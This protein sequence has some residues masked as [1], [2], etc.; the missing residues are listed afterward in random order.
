MNEKY[1][2]KM[3]SCIPLMFKLLLLNCSK[4]TFSPNKTDA[5]VVRAGL[6]SGVLLLQIFSITIPT[7]F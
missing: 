7:A 1:L 2:V 5:S 3:F 4:T 6:L